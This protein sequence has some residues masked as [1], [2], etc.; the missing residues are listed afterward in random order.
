ARGGIGAGR[1]VAA[2]PR[3]SPRRE[4]GDPARDVA[5]RHRRHGT[6][7]ALAD[8]GRVRDGA[9][10]L[11]VL[12]ASRRSEGDGG[13]QRA[14]RD[15][16]RRGARGRLPRSRGGPVPVAL[17]GRRVRGAPDPRSLASRRARA[18]RSPGARGGSRARPRSRAE[19]R[20]HARLRLARRDTDSGRRRRIGAR[21]RGGLGARGGAH[22]AALA[23]PS[24][25]ARRGHRA[26]APVRATAAEHRA[27]GVANHPLP[28]GA[29]MRAP[30][31]APTGAVTRLVQAVSL[32]TVFGLLY[33]A[34]RL[35]PP[36]RE[37]LGE[38]AAIG[39]LLLC[40]TLLSELLET[41]GLP[42]LSGYLLAGV[43]A[44]PHVLHLVDHHTV[45]RLSPVN[46]LALALI[47]IAGGAELRV[48]MLK[49]VARSVAWALL[50]Q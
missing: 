34:A 44:G 23:A 31:G 2:R 27:A 46:T 14:T 49:S 45:E 19:Q 30:S 17:G 35:A 12:P 36:L 39:F 47:A 38:I 50:L 42:R 18:D 5:P 8:R 43:V 33:G 40:G 29:P 22:R 10:G 20:V 1:D 4:L 26:G 9:H 6:P 41:I 13:A 25:G 37:H 16:A 28:R 7:R 48:S 32:V 24:A 15:G 3:V 11:H 21:A